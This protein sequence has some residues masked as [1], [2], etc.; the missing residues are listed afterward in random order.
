MK[1]FLL[2]F[3]L[4]ILGVDRAVISVEGKQQSGQENQEANQRPPS[5]RTRNQQ[6]SAN[7]AANQAT[8]QAANQNQ[9]DSTDVP[10]SRN[11]IKE[12]QLARYISTNHAIWR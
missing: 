8:N 11:E 2:L 7:Q 6:S 3:F 5:R 1:H 9:Q 12:Y 10:N 4:E